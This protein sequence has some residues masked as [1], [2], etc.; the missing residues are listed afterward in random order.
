MKRYILLFST[1]PLLSNSITIYNNNLAHVREHKAYTF[2]QGLQTIEFENLPKTIIVDSISPVFSSKN[3]RLISQNYTFNPLTLE[4]LLEAN[5]NKEIQFKYSDKSPLMDAKLINLHPTVVESSGSYYIA[6]P[7][8]IVFKNLPKLKDITPK[9]KWL[10]NTKSETK[11]ELDLSYL[12]NQVN[13]S[14]NYTLVLDKEQ[15]SLKAWAK[16][17][18]KSGKSYRDSNISLVAGELHSKRAMQGRN[19]LYKSQAMTLEA[20]AAMIKPK[21]MS[22]YY[23]YDLPYAIELNNNETKQI[24]LIDASAVK[25]K[26]YAIAYNR[27]FNNYKEAQLAF[28][29]V[30]EFTNSKENSLGLPLPQGLVRV[31]EANHYL[32]EDTIRNKAVDEKV[33]VNIGTLFD[34]TGIKKISKFISNNNYRDVATTYTI[35]NRAKEVITIKINEAVQR[36]GK[37]INFKSTCKGACSIKKENAFTRVY[38]INLKPKQTYTFTSEYEIFY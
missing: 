27:N 16:I 1:L 6:N 19:V 22:G 28:S 20:D 12:I 24:A 10:V 3:V 15:L 18:N 29:Q 17:T 34:V 30:I 38:T 7:N 36:Y 11:T 4:H 25:Y 33:K 9:L 23:I 8:N 26:R 21:A 32:G 37:K 5:L 2:Q 13:W 35:N 14:S 31:Y